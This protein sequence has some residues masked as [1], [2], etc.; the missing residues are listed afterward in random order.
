MYVCAMSE[1]PIEF[2]DRIKKQF[3]KEADELIRS[4]DNRVQ[5][6]IRINKE[7]KKPIFKG[8]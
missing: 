7:K 6:S 8:H 5:P 4:L 1:L 3:P 2:I